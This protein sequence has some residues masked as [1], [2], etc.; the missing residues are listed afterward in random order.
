MAT[1]LCCTIQH[2]TV[3]HGTIQHI[4]VYLTTS[5]QSIGSTAQHGTA[6]H[7]R[8]QHST[9]QPSIAGLLDSLF[10]I[11][12]VLKLLAGD[13]VQDVS[14]PLLDDIVGDLVPIRTPRGRA[15][16]CLSGQVVEGGDVPQHGHRLQQHM[17]GMSSP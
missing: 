10:T 8:A 17:I 14:Q 6:Q 16:Y 2:T 12:R 11:S 1:Q 3:Q 13:L 15:L 7:S 4:C 9:T 5:L